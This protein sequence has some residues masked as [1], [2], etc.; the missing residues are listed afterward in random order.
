M[1]LKHYSN[2]TVLL[3]SVLSYQKLLTAR[4]VIF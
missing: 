3:E 2:K 4:A 1:R